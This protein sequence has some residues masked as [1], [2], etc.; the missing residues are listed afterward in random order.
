MRPVAWGPFRGRE[1]R[2]GQAHLGDG[3][4]QQ[5]TQETISA[6]TPSC[7]GSSVGWQ[8]PS[9]LPVIELLFLL[10]V[11]RVL[12]PASSVSR[13]FPG[14]ALSC[15][16]VILSRWLKQLFAL[17]AVEQSLSSTSQT[18]EPGLSSQG[19]GRGWLHQARCSDFFTGRACDC[20][21]QKGVMKLASILRFTP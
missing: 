14:K 3:V 18:L 10:F 12:P 20:F 7:P 21:A 2:Y 17:G 15:G 8:Q 11:F 4:C 16:Q 9:S 19:R 5:A 1:Q 6:A 13:L